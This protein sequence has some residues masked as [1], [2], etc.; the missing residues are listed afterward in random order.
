M[1]VKKK[2]LLLGPLS[3]E[4]C[5]PN[6]PSFHPSSDLVLCMGAVWDFRS[7]YMVHRFERFRTKGNCMENIFH[8]YGHT[9]LIDGQ[10]VTFWPNH[11]FSSIDWSIH[12]SSDCSIDWLIDS[13]I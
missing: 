12:Q 4:E 6:L 8:A 3:D 10:V 9:V 11:I 1:E 5:H 2:L 13:S 7:G